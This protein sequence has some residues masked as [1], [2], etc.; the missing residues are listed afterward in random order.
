MHAEPHDEPAVLRGPEAATPVPMAS[1][2]VAARAKV[3]AANSHKAPPDVFRAARSFWRSL[4]AFSREPCCFG[5]GGVRGFG[6]DFGTMR[7]ASCSTVA[8]GLPLDASATRA[9]ATNMA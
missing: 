8:S 3:D 6:G 4:R 5:T 1:A 7:S 9:V 2:V